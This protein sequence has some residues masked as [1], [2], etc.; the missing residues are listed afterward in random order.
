M[1]KHSYAKG[2]FTLDAA[3]CVFRSGLH[4]SRYRKFSISLQKC[5][6]LPQTH[7]ENAVMSN[8]SGVV[9]H[10]QISITYWPMTKE[11]YRYLCRYSIPL[12]TQ[13]SVQIEET[14]FS[15][16]L[17]NLRK[18]RLWIGWMHLG[19]RAYR[20]CCPTQTTI[21]RRRNLA[22]VLKIKCSFNIVMTPTLLSKVLLY[23]LT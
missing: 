13:Y 1:A 17:P 6:H 19:K 12:C 5:N 7:A 21:D 11:L 15:V 8:W 10:Q 23:C 9:V 3:V 18:F 2:W 22:P 20:N 14:F 16:N 4:Q